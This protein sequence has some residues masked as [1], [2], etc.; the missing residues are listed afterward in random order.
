MNPRYTLEQLGYSDWG[1]LDNK[2][3]TW[4]YEGCNR[5]A[6][7]DKRDALNKEHGDLD[8]DTT[9][10]LCADCSAD[11]DGTW[12]I[13]SDVCNGCWDIAAADLAD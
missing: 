6:A 7:E 5:D 13:G 9:D 2:T 1:V 12:P 11:N 3:E 4:V 10:A 8:E